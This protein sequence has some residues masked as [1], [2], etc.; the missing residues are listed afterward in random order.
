MPGYVMDGSNGEN[1]SEDSEGYNL[2]GKEIFVEKSPKSPLST[3][4][5]SSY[6]AD[7]I[8]LA[9]DGEVDN[10]IEQLYRNIC[11]IQSSDHSPSMRSFYS[12]GDESRIDS[13]LRFFAGV[14]Y[15]VEDVQKEVLV[16]KVVGEKDSEV[17][18]LE[19]DSGKV[20]S[21]PQ[22]KRTNLEACRKSSSRSKTLHGRPP[23]GKPSG[24]GSKRLNTVFSK[25]EVS[26]PFAGKKWPYGSE[27]QR[28]AGY[29]GPYLLKQA[30]NLVASGDNNCQKALE[31]ALRAMKSFEFASN[32]K[33]NLDFV[34]C[35][36]TV[37]ALYCRLCR[38]TEAIPI[39]ERSIKI[40]VVDLGHDHAVAKFAGCMQLGDTYAILDQY[41]NSLLLYTEGLDIQRHVLGEKHPQFG[42]TCRYIAEAQVQAMQF[43][44]AEKLCL[45]ALDIHKENK[46]SGS[47]Q[48]IADRRLM[49]LICD[50][51]GDYE[52][53]LEHY[54]LARMA[55]VGNGQTAEVADIDCNIG[56]AYL[57]LDRY[58]EAVFTYQKALN[59]FKSSKGE[60]HS[61]VA[62]LYIRLADL[63]NK[64]GKFAEC[65]SY[66]ENALRI[67]DKPSV[68]SLPE[69]IASGLVDISAI[70]ESMQRPNRA[71]QLLQRA[72]KVYCDETVQLSVIAGVEAQ[73]GSLYYILGRYFES[74]RS[75]KSAISMFRETGEKKSAIFGVVLNQFGLACMQLSLLDEAGDSFEEAKIVLETVCGPFHADTLG[76]YS[77]LAGI[78][79][80]MGRTSDAIQILDYVVEMREEKIGTTKPNV[81][82][83]KRLLSKLLK[84]SGMAPSRRSKSRQ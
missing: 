82:D 53:S 17:E 3:H 31:L 45:V 62:M 59:M 37:A 11:E 40:P 54:I 27:N 10:S 13:E 23:T 66:C 67:Y 38:Y 63:Y 83:E 26:P 60:N 47:A 35:L 64:I 34:M 44:E 28:E 22:A 41:E 65:E 72:I 81:E 43:D 12:Y 52:G 36:H 73:M 80:A 55:M 77:N 29:L 19:Q 25:N 16:E 68:G 1:I 9:L 51:K 56:D 75:L 61:L 71:L 14:D 50:S 46:T 39:L 15:A 4:T 20:N 24:K 48:E 21:P 30:R 84:E 5:M 70:Y 8:E 78:Y 57:S 79:D 42:E 58:E 7:S 76:V 18:I 2:H 69:E 74:Y 6:D 49:G 32:A 33:P